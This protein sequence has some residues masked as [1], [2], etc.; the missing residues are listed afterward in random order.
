M[1]QVDVI[2]NG[3]NYRIACDDGQE[4]HLKQLAELVDQ[5]LSQ[6]VSTV[7]EIGE[8]R[9]LVM[10]CLVVADELME[11]NG[12]LQ[13]KAGK[14]G[15]VATDAAVAAATDAL[16]KRIETITQRLQAT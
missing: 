14:K 13:G 3:H 15:A 5:R 1:A 10:T 4:A 6:L 7:G 8:S 9:L 11:A 2:I 12:E 16:A